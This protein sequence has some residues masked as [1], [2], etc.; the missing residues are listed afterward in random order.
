MSSPRQPGLD[1]SPDR[2]FARGIEIAG[3]FEADDTLRAQRTVEQVLQDLRLRRRLG[4]LLPCEVAL[5]EL[6]GLEH[7]AALADGHGTPVKQKLQRPLRRFAA[8]PQVLLVH[9]HVIVDVA[10]REWA[11]STQQPQHLAQV[12]VRDLAEPDTALLPAA[13]HGADIERHSAGRQIGQGVRPVLEHRLVDAL[14][15]PQVLAPIGRNAR[16]QDMMVAALDHV[17]GVDLHVAEVF[18]GGRCRSGAVAERRA[19]IEPLRAQPD[20]S[21]ARPGEGDRFV[22]RAGHAWAAV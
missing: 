14:R 4:Q 3:G 17:D 11:L 6:I 20:A 16:V 5:G 22:G 12:F 10:D 18:D 1:Q 13:L 19:L 15:L 9:Q 21:G 8:R 7:S 2:G